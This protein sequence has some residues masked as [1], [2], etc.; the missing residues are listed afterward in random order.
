MTLRRLE[1]LRMRRVDPASPIL[2]KREIYKFLEESY[3]DHAVQY[4]IGAMQ[5]IDSDY[6][7]RTLEER[8]RVE[9]QLAKGFVTAGVGSSFDYQGSVTNDT[10][11]KAHS[12]VDLLTVEP[13]WHTVAVPVSPYKGNALQDLT[14]LRHCSIATLRAS[15]PAAKVDVSG[16]KAVSISGG[17][18]KRKVDVI[19][20]AYWHTEEYLR[21]PGHSDLLLGI[22][23]LDS[24]ANDR[25]PNKPFLHN[26]RI[27]ER[28]SATLGGLRKVIRL[29]KSLKYDSDQEI[30]ISSY[31]ICGLSYNI[32]DTLMA[33]QRG[34]DLR[35]VE[36]ALA[37]LQELVRN[38][39]LRNSIAV[40]NSMRKVFA[41]DG[42]SEH[43]LQQLTQALYELHRDIE[44]GMRRSFRKLAEAR[45]DY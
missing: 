26:T 27:E 14:T 28:D 12:D 38:A 16:A 37:Y 23:V 25:V 4:A 24:H 19:A 5:P 9:D 40:P 31:D 10:H 7:K 41:V 43:G 39:T 1:K 42:A 18:L 44:M 34:F 32:P 21:D 30:D 45:I 29:L 11:I 2:G 35:L 8:Q 33:V 17:S 3:E 13:R 15:Y 36:G 22:E 20:C 6:T